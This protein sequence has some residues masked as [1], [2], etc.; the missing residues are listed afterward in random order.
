[1]KNILDK[2]VKEIQKLLFDNLWI[3]F[4]DITLS[5]TKNT[6]ALELFAKIRILQV[7]KCVLAWL[8]ILDFVLNVYFHDIP[9]GTTCIIQ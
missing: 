2:D 6:E 9:Y 5:D 8:F 3:E 7:L 1:M 4:Q